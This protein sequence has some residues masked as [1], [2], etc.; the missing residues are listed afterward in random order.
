LVYATPASFGS[1][2]ARSSGQ[3]IL[4]RSFTQFI[5]V[6]LAHGRWKLTRSS[7]LAQPTLTHGIAGLWEGGLR[8]S[9]LTSSAAPSDARATAFTRSR[10]GALSNCSL[11]SLR[12]SLVAAVFVGSG[13]T[14]GRARLTT[15]HGGFP[16][17]ACRS[18]ARTSPADS[19]VAPRATHVHPRNRRV[20]GRWASLVAPHFLSGA[21]RRARNGLHA[22]APRISPWP[23]AAR[24]RQSQPTRGGSVARG[25][26]T[27]SR[28]EVWQCG[29]V[30]GG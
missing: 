27:L 6:A 4:D 10:T 29:D 28:D 1:Q 17:S 23:F 9:L 12:C 25:A 20:M 22:L 13:E 14:D 21:L 15:S 8:S 2:V 30:G 3:L 5:E 7:R 19:F 16:V 11:R 26:A 24:R 18:A